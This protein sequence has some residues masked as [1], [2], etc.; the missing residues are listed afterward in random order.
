MLRAGSWMSMARRM[1]VKMKVGVIWAN[2][3]KRKKLRLPSPVKSVYI[4]VEASR[5][6]VPV[7]R[8]RAANTKEYQ[9]L[10]PKCKR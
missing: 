3:P 2:R 5:S 9:S 4:V 10:F 7:N 6:G 1:K 8:K